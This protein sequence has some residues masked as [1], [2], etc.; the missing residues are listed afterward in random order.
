MQTDYEIKIKK[1]REIVK[2]IVVYD[3]K[4]II[5]PFSF[6]KL[7]FIKSTISGFILPSLL[8]ACLQERIRKIF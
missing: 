5:T 8:N 7:G 3:F 6:L 1:E 2:K 4:E